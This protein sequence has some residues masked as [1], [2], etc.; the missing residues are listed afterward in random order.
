MV[1]CPNCRHE[2]DTSLKF[3]ENCGAKLARKCPNCGSPVSGNA[4]F[5][6][7]CGY[8]LETEVDPQL[9]RLKKLVP[10]ELAERLLTSRHGKIER[11]RRIVT[12]LF[13]DVK[14]STALG[15]ERDPE[16]VLEIMNGAFEVLIEPI[17]R[18]EG[19][20]ARLMG[21]AIL[22]F[23]GAPIAHEDD[24]VRAALAA[25]DIQQ[26]MP[27]YAALVAKKYGAKGFSVR[28]GINTGLV[29]VGEVGSDLRVEYTAMGDAINVASRLENAAAPGAIVV[30]GNTARL[31]RHAFDLESLGGLELK[32][33][34]EPVQAY[35]VVKKKETPESPRGIQGLHSPLVGRAREFQ[36][37]KSSVEGL[38]GGRGQ[39]VS[40]I[41]EA[42]LGKSRLLEEVKKA[43]RGEKETRDQGEAVTLE[44]GDEVIPLWLEGKALSYQT[45]TP[46]APFQDLFR[47]LFG[48]LPEE[49]D[50]DKYEKVV[51]VIEGALPG[52]AEEIGP[53]LAV[54]LGIEL[55]EQD[56]DRIKYLT[57]PDL[58]E[59]IYLS[60][61]QFLSALAQKQP[62]VLVLE[63]LHWADAS[64]LDLVERLMPLAKGNKIAIIALFRPQRQDPS[65]RF[66]EVASRDYHPWYISIQLEPL[67]EESARE[68]VANL[69][70]IEDLPPQVRALVLKKAEGNP[71]YVE[72]V[73]RSLLDAKLVVRENSHWRATRE[74][75]TIQVPDSLSAVITA[76]LDRLDD[77]SK[78]TAQTA[79]VVG[80]EFQFDILAE[81]AEAPE[82]L[83]SSLGNLERRE[84]IREKSRAPLGEYL[85]K[86]AV[87][88]ETA[89]A[90][91]LMSK[92]RDLHRRVADCLERVDPER[93]NE[94]A[95]HLVEAKEMG[96]ALPFLIAAGDRASRSYSIPEAIGYFN[97]AVEIAN[98]G[99]NI[100]LARR[101]YEG[102]GAAQSFAFNIPAAIQIYEEM[103]D[104]AKTH[105]D[106][107]MQVSAINK[108]AFTL[109][110][111]AGQ[112]PSADKYLGEAEKLASQVEDKPGLVESYF[113]RCSMCTAVGDFD[114]V[115]YYMSRSA[116]FGRELNLQDQVAAAL[117]HTARSQMLMTRFEEAWPTSQEALNLARQ[118]KNRDL[119]AMIL[120]TISGLHMRNGDLEAA[121]QA[122]QEGRDIA[123]RIG[124]M[125]GS[126]LAPWQLGTVLRLEGD[127]TGAIAGLQESVQH[128]HP[129]ENFMPY[130][131][132]WPLASLGSTYAEVGPAFHPRT[133]QMHAH[134][135]ELLATPGGTPAAGTAFADLGFTALE[136]DRLDDAADA[137]QKGL[138]YPS[139]F[140]YLW[141]PQ[142]QLGQ[143]LV[144]V[145]RNRLEEA[146][147]TVGD[148]R[149]YVDK[150]AMRSMYPMVAYVQGCVNLAAGEPEK[151]L[152]E[153]GRA[154]VL[155]L[156]MKMRP[157]VWQSRAGAAQVLAAM[158]RAEEAER[159]RK[160][161]RES[162][163]EIAGLFKDLEMR[164]AF[165]ENAMR[166]IA[167]VEESKQ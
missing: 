70:E 59:R 103:D 158:G 157:M 36:I 84:I 12:I 138:N 112:F 24:P 38:A 139:M 14:G 25:L 128:A 46:Y 79:A 99:E 81:V 113:V 154:E 127:Y 65:W 64:S 20:L 83:E 58:R 166:K 3:C 30:S 69:L 48:I 86:H 19:T 150:R 22:A 91:I 40:I 29:V 121:R 147:K 132:A 76:R 108:L 148:A 155:S 27:E 80:R 160:Q 6:G 136:Q 135:L 49:K 151:A 41:G 45:T 134:T 125:L 153:F 101:A 98:S 126:V 89:Y 142:L 43:G 68:L 15:E 82:I 116:D 8:Q 42:G 102:L 143:A 100:G 115:V 39:L 73:I 26:K 75:A 52:R 51:Q 156:E 163:D 122:A 161:A 133:A 72:E 97:R 107:P 28:V 129:L 130:A 33:K 71:F 54:M 10:K 165:V 146:A 7:N 34:A 44:R 167:M 106:V 16:E 88:Q 74:I 78:R 152:G 159:K 17:Y 21:D 117:D 9:T 118:I 66:H 63:D 141:Q 1:I 35:R 13:S 119:E 144:A 61:G 55:M 4:K 67:D 18:Y 50:P 92:R 93:V 60:A 37:L 145:R 23:F 2:N 110:F 137:F 47:R 120:T 57:P 56:L 105:G 114:A 124:S 131:L 32:G 111:S 53:F 90:T 149:A 31:I 87:T 94:I 104:W 96:R 123:L 5:C 162:V 164:A 109:A 77:D 140:R 85:F 62:L 95:W 11:E